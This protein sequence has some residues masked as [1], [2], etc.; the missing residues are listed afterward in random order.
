MSEPQPARES[1]R[2]SGPEPGESEAARER[3]SHVR[4]ELRAP[5]AVLYPLISLLRTEAAGP[6]TATQREYVDMM[7][8]HV[9]RLNALVASA[10]ESGWLDCAAAPLEPGVVSLRDVAEEVVSRLKAGDGASHVRVVADGPEAPAWTDREQVGCILHDLLD[11][12]A[13]YASGCAVTVEVGGSAGAAV[14]VL[15]VRDQGPG[16]CAEDV[17]QAFDFGF[18]GEAAREAGVAGLGAGLWTCRRLAELNRGTIE[19]DSAEGRGTTVIL[20][21]PAARG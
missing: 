8:R 20:T 13:R 16:M 15:T 12:A 19:L 14:A 21:L 6:L 9:E 17:R 3:Q 11:N 7:E 1:Q 2:T 18:R 10:A 5:L 4:H